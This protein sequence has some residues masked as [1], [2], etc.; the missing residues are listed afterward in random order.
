MVCSALIQRPAG[1]YSAEIVPE[2][3]ETEMQ[4]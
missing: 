2:F 1:A 3:V 4:Q